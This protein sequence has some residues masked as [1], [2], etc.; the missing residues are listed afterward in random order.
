MPGGVGAAGHAAQHLHADLEPLVGVPAPRR[1]ED[2]TQ[3]NMASVGS[4]GAVGAQAVDVGRGRKSALSTCQ[5]AQAAAPGA[6]PDGA[7]RP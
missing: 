3:K 4:L 2:I 7:P 1:I 5:Q 6:P